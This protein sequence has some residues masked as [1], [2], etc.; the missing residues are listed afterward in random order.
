MKSGSKL[1]LRRDGKGLRIRA[2]DRRVLSLHVVPGGSVFVNRRGQ[3]TVR[4]RVVARGAGGH[5]EVWDA[6]AAGGRRSA[7]RNRF[8]PARRRAR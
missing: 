7:A 6:R 4:H 2:S 8:V 3:R 1:Q 5:F